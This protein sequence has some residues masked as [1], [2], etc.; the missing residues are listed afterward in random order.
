[1]K[2]SCSIFW[3]QQ[4]CEWMNGFLLCVWRVWSVFE[5]KFTENA[6]GLWSSNPPYESTAHIRNGMYILWA[7]VFRIKHWNKRRLL[8]LRIFVLFF[9]SLFV[10]CSTTAVGVAFISILYEWSV[11]GNVDKHILNRRNVKICE[12]S[13]GNPLKITSK[14]E[15]HVDEYKIKW[16]TC[17]CCWANGG[18]V[19][20]GMVWGM[21]TLYAFMW[22]KWLRSGWNII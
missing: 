5:T 2:F 19:W 22:W 18:L 14:Y 3:R 6:N 17:C 12:I 16:H 11:A 9:F 21:G 10:Q 20:Y 4:V 13:M 15:F 1:M 7:F 8:L